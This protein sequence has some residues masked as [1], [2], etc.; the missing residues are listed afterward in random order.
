MRRP[1]RTGEND[2][3]PLFSAGDSGRTAHSHTLSFRS[4][5]ACLV[6]IRRRPFALS[7]GLALWLLLNG[8][9]LASSNVPLHHWS[10]DAIERLIGLG[11][12]DHALIGAKPFSR[13]QAAQYVARAV[14][15]VRADQVEL[16]GREAIAEPLLE[17]LLAEFRP[18]L[19][20]LGTVRARLDDKTGA[21]RFGAR[22]TSEFDASSIG[23]GQT[24]RFRENRGGEYSVNGVQN[25]TD[26]RAWAELS[27]WAAVMVQPK[28]ISNRHLLG[29]GATNNSENFYLREF[30]LKLSYANV[31]LEV[32]RGTIE[33]GVPFQA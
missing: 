16:D 32:G 1:L 14:E 8:I 20:R 13:M 11:V 18:E 30:S 2:A 4:G 23:G 33:T 9:A 28:F 19:I 3:S 5:P 12:I 27:D 10:Y 25:Q 21:L 31:A 15:R 6:K 26:V 7:L 17:R 22:V 29:L 24:V